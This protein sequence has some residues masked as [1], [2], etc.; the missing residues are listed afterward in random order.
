[1]I[2]EKVKQY[3]G[4]ETVRRQSVSLIM[5][6]ENNMEK[7]MNVCKDKESKQGNSIAT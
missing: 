6:Q 5:V 4:Q 3:T 7:N 1:M 2:L